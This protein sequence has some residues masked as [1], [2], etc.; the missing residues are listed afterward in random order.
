MARDPR[1]RR[2]P[3]ARSALLAAS[4]ADVAWPGWIPEALRRDI[5]RNHHSPGHWGAVALGIE[6]TWRDGAA[7]PV[8]GLPVLRTGALVRALTEPRSQA[9]SRLIAVGRYV[10]VHRR[11]AAFVTVWPGARAGIVEP[12]Q[13]ARGLDVVEACVG[14][15]GLAEAELRDPRRA[16][17]MPLQVWMPGDRVRVSVAGG[18]TRP[19]R[20]VGMRLET[21]RQPGPW[22]VAVRVGRQV[23][24][25]DPAA[26]W[27]DTS[28]PRGVAAFA[29]AGARL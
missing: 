12:I 3:V 21:K 24:W 10:A 7:V 4:W 20:V 5:T 6:L 19:G 15:P 11:G 28:I 17:P 9:T 22:R 23:V 16:I 27:H 25:R 2:D 26:I 8:Y 14:V 29:A 18:A 13:P 1:A